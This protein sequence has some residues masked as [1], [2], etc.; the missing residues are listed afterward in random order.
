MQFGN[1]GSHYARSP[2]PNSFRDNHKKNKRTL[3]HESINHT[4][5]VTLFS[6]EYT[7]PIYN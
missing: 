7:K 4:I 6:I 2:T 1:T 5:L 3:Y